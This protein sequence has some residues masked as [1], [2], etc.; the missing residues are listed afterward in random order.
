MNEWMNEWLCVYKI[1][2]QSCL[3]LDPCNSRK[4][5]AMRD[6]LQTMYYLHDLFIKHANIPMTDPCMVY[7]YMLTWLGYL[8]MVNGKALIYHTY[9]DPS[10]DRLRRRSCGVHWEPSSVCWRWRP[11]LY[12]RE[13]SWPSCRRLGQA[14]GQVVFQHQPLGGSIEMM[15]NGVHKW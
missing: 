13:P 2:V 7:I 3:D 5:N 11:W 14:V 4:N 15:M 6:T 8:L 12:G 10:W 9:M 1:Y